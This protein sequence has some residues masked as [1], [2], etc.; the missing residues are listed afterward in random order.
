MRDEGLMIEENEYDQEARSA[1][2]PALAGG[3]LTI[4]DEVEEL[5]GRLETTFPVEGTKIDWSDVPGSIYQF[6]QGGQQ[7]DYERFFHEN[8]LKM[9]LDTPAYYLSDAALS[10]AIA[11]DVR[12]MKQWLPAILANPQHHYFTARDFSWCMALT[13]EGGMNFGFR[14]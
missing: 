8:E 3:Q 14:P 11:G 4:I 5:F 12:S 10:F 2:G 6:S 13:M 7:E 9:G 1:L